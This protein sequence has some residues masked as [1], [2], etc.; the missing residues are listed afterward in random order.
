MLGNYGT[1]NYELQISNV[2]S[3]EINISGLIKMYLMLAY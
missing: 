1:I 3:F 2:H